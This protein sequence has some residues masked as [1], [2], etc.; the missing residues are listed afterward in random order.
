MS[1]SRNQLIKEIKE[2]RK[3]AKAELMYVKGLTKMKKEELNEVYD[4]LNEVNQTL[5]DDF[6]D[7][8]SAE[9]EQLEKEKEILEQ[10]LNT[11]EQDEENKKVEIEELEDIENEE[12]DEE[13]ETDE[14]DAPREKPKLERQNATYIPPEESETEDSEQE[15]EKAELNN[16]DDKDDDKLIDAEEFLKGIQDTLNR[17]D[18]VFKDKKKDKKEKKQQEITPKKELEKEIKTLMSSFGGEITTL[19]KPFQRKHRYGRLDNFDI[20]DIIDNHNDLREET[21]NKI[22]LIMDELSENDDFSEAFYRY[23]N[24]YFERQLNRVERLLK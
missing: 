9:K 1:K 8:Y 7:E 19:L 10:E 11:L 20:D 17:H 22:D 12:F 16:D 21:K 3:N 5:Q 4:M 23:V 14:E 6:N 2:K 18:K 13:S 15:T 24:N